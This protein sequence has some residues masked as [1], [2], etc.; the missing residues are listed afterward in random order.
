MSKNYS[1]LK[2]MRYEDLIK[3]HDDAANPKGAAPTAVGINYYLDELRYREQS[4]I[5]N[6]IWWFTLVVTVATIFSIIL[7]YMMYLKS[8]T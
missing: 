2:S 8:G 3:L 6:Q 1:S 5:T 7:T 4:K